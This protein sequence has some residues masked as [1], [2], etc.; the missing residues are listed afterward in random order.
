MYAVSLFQLFPIVDEA[1]KQVEISLSLIPK[2]SALVFCTL[3]PCGP[4][5]IVILGI[6]SL[7]IALLCQ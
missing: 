1:G 6:S 3:S 5:D 4:S 7:S 2:L